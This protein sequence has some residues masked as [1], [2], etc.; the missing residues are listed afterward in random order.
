MSD[1]DELVKLLNSNE[2]PEAVPPFLICDDSDNDKFD[3]AEGIIDY[4]NYDLKDKKFLDFGCGEGHVVKK[5]A[6]D[7]INAFGYDIKQSDNFEWTNTL[8]T[9]IEFIK[10]NKPYDVILLYDVLDNADDPS[11]IL[12]LIKNLC[13]KNTKIHVRCHPWTSRHGSHLYYQLNKA[14]IH[15]IFNDI[16]LSKLG[17]NIGFFNKIYAPIAYNQK[18]FKENNLKI[19]KHETLKNPIENFFKNN[20]IINARLSKMYKGK[21]PD[22][23]L[24]QSFNDYVL[25]I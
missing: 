14:Y 24:S 4:I 5:L 20:Q 23:Q 16:E 9:D 6:T 12:K 8:T 7:G 25:Q 10:H 19:L 18:W 21:F 13:N 17:I 1:F 11:N 22:F 3:R 15:L 2:W